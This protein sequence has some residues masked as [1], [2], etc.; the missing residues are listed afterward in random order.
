MR[1]TA[2]EKN[3]DRKMH[4]QYRGPLVVICR[5]CRGN[6][7]VTEMNGTVYKDKV[8]AWRLLPHYKH[9]KPI[10]LPENIHE[11]IDLTPEQLEHMINEEEL[12]SDLVF[13]SMPKLRSP[14]DNLGV[15]DW[16]DIDKS[17]DNEADKS[18]NEEE[19]CIMHSHSKRSTY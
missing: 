18:G 2:I 15:D 12:D 9:Y 6:F 11:L 1:N 14:I 17:S 7:I 16:E 10:A 8:V 4:L 5:M 19:V 13:D 3:L